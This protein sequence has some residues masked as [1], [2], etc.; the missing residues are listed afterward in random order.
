[1]TTMKV[2]G[3][4]VS[5]TIEQKARK[6]S[7]W[8]LE[9]EG[10]A[11]AVTSGSKPNTAYVVRHDGAHCQYCPCQSG[12]FGGRCAHKVAGDAFLASQRRAAY[13]DMFDVHGLAFL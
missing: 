9:G 12:K 8:T 5:L 7:V 4:T 13:A 1:M 6:L 10:N 2:N 3:K 11:L